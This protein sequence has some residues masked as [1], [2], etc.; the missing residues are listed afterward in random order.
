[1]HAGDSEIHR[2]GKEDSSEVRVNR[3][4]PESL[5]RSLKLLDAEPAIQDLFVLDRVLWQGSLTSLSCL[6]CG[7]G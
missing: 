6:W 7:P 1:M 4:M 5:W 3:L 2:K